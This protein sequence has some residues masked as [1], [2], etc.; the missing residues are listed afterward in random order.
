MM[1]MITHIL[2][3]LARRYQYLKFE[4]KDYKMYL[5]LFNVVTKLFRLRSNMRSGISFFVSFSLRLLNKSVEGP[6]DRCAHCWGGHLLIK[7]NSQGSI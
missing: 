3:K 5:T 7:A 6:T 4:Q 2:H 1:N